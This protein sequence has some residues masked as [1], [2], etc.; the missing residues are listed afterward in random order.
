[1]SKLCFAALVF[2]TATS[3]SLAQHFDIRGYGGINFV[4]L[5]TDQGELNIDGIIHRRSIEGRPGAQ[6]GFAVTFGDQ[7]YVQP[8]LQFST[9][10]TRVINENTSTG[11]ELT[12]ET[13]LSLISVPLKFGFRLIP[14]DTENFINVRLFGGF[15][16]HHVTSVDHSLNDPATAEIDEDDYNNL[17]INADFG[18]GLDFW[19]L[20]ID[21]GYQIG[22][23]PIHASGDDATASAFYTNLG[24]RISL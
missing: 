13:T 22:L 24:V 14:P 9:I 1:M 18:L 12:D 3:T 21:A 23:T 2:L 11:N 7:F 5:S 19:F 16:G 17:I 4:H 8:G 6:Y 10:S 15:D 20:F